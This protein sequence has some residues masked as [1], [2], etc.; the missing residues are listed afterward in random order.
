MAA[1][2]NLQ[3]LLLFDF[4]AVTQLSPL[5]VLGKLRALTVSGFDGLNNPRGWDLSIFTVCLQLRVRFP[6]EIIT[7]WLSTWPVDYTVM[8][9]SP[10]LVCW[11]AL[12]LKCL[13]DVPC[14]QPLSSLALLTKLT[15]LVLPS[16]SAGSLTSCPAAAELLLSKLLASLKG[17]SI[18]DMASIACCGFQDMCTWAAWCGA[19]KLIHVRHRSC[20]PACFGRARHVGPAMAAHSL[21]GRAC[22]GWCSGAASWRQLDLVEM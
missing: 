11:Q 20:R 12:T 18:S 19:Q 15:F 17:N 10:M 4:K 7:L 5:S 1:L 6:Q 8:Q 22:A 2:T 14:L 16:T 21:H 13:V 3:T 9:Q